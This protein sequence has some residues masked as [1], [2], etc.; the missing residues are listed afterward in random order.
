MRTSHLWEDSVTAT[1]NVLGCGP[2]PTFLTEC[3]AMQVTSMPR[4]LL[5]IAA[6][7]LSCGAGQAQNAASRSALGATSPLSGL[8]S[9]TSGAPT[10]IPLGATEINPGGL[11]S[12]A[13]SS[14]AFSSL[15]GSSQSGAAAGTTFD[16]GGKVF[17]GCKHGPTPTGSSTRHG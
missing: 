9:P 15:A 5:T 10:G 8:G 1:R 16:G 4:Y 11:S 14:A 7:L 2:H 12:L 6:I 3:R 17:S 13:C